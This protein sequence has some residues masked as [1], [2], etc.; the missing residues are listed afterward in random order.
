M[1]SPLAGED[2][3]KILISNF[4]IDLESFILLLSF[5]NDGDFVM[6]DIGT[7]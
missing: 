1:T 6:Y 2:D 3:N 5:F 4:F 7:L